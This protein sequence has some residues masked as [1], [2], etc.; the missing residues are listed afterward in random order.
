MTRW[1]GI[2]CLVLFLV[3]P[4]FGLSAKPRVRF[5]LARVDALNLV[6]G[7][8]QVLRSWAELG[9][10]F[11]WMTRFQDPKR[12]VKVESPN[13]QSHVWRGRDRE[14]YWLYYQARGHRAQRLTACHNAYQPVWSPNSREVAYFAMDWPSHVRGLY[15]IAPQAGKVSKPRLE[16]SADGHLGASASWSPDGGKIVFDYYGKLW[17]VNSNGIGRSLLDLSGRMHQP[18]LDAQRIAWNKDGSRL[19]WQTHGESKVTVMD[20]KRIAY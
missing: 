4:T 18:V 17:I 16:F 14:G 7:R 1:R 9:P 2:V 11:S 8:I 6:L 20:L 15:V 3:A 10:D 12:V 5:P 19:A 13:G